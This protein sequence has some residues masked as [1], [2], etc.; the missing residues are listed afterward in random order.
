M[1]KGRVKE[2]LH[3]MFLCNAFGLAQVIDVH[4]HSSLCSPSNGQSP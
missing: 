1:P 4:V 3:A 2:K